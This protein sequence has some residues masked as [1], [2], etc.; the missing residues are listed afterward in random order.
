MPGEP[1]ALLG[2][3]GAGETQAAPAVTHGVGRIAQCKVQARRSS[4]FVIDFHIGDSPRMA[5]TINSQLSAVRHAS[6][7]VSCAVLAA[8]ALILLTHPAAAQTAGG[9]GSLT[10][11]L[12]NVANLITG[13]AGQVIAVIAVALTGLGAMFGA[14]SARNFGFVVL[15]CAIVFSAAWIVGQITGGTVGA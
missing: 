4:A 5:T 12:Q 10:T 1:G 11:F 7:L 9:T 13:T 8:T 15:G 14:I 3:I 6:K 2:S